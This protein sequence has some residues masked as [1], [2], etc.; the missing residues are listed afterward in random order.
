MVRYQSMLWKN[1]CIQLQV[2]KTLNPAT[3]LWVNSGPQEHDCLEIMD[4]V[5]S[6]RPGLTNQPISYP[7]VEYFTD[8]N[9]FDCKDTHFARYTVVT[10]DAVIKNITTASWDF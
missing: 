10:L 4:E 3:L 2:V 8:G 5:F 7:D 9:S 1:L 6:H